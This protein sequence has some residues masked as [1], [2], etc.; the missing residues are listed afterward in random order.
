MIVSEYERPQEHAS[1]RH[2]HTCKTI[3]LLTHYIIIPVLPL[4]PLKCFHCYIH[5]CIFL[6]EFIWRRNS[7]TEQQKHVYFCPV[8]YLFRKFCFGQFLSHQTM[9]CPEVWTFDSPGF[10]ATE[11]IHKEWTEV[12]R[13]KLFNK[14]E[15]TQQM[16]ELVSITK[17]YVYI[18]LQWDSSSRT[19]SKNKPDFSSL[20]YNYC[21]LS[22]L[23]HRDTT[24]LQGRGP[25]GD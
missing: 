3:Y 6:L 20:W 18:P 10:N 13:K 21:R 12:T 22:L 16:T 9:L 15:S 2:V 23:G 19:G 24:E 1:K 5:N 25:G 4:S 17:S 14:I 11:V 8:V 7:R